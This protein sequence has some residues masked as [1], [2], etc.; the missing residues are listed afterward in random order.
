MS[1]F[2]KVA[3]LASVG[4]LVVAQSSEAQHQVRG[5]RGRVFVGTPFFGG[6]FFGG[7]WGGLGGWGGG[8]PYGGGW[9]GP[10][11][12]LGYGGWGGPSYSYSS[13]YINQ[14]ISI[15]TSMNVT[16]NN[17][18]L[19]DEKQL[20]PPE[21]PA[22]LEV[23]VPDNATVW[24]DGRKTQQTGS[25]RLFNTPPLSTSGVYTYDVRA[26]WTDSSGT[27]VVRTQSVS[28]SPKQRATVDFVDASK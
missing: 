26:A 5:G 27:Q 10:W 1:L 22:S 21:D 4:V 2:A 28:V 25:V 15:F 18:Y 24:I 3:V 7:G 12:G 20:F 14:P 17:Y 8:W 11:G 9:G 19:K 6:P 13:T 23:K 16:N